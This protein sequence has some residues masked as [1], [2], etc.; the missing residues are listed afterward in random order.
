MSTSWIGA[1]IVVLIAVLCGARGRGAVEGFVSIF[2]E[3][4]GTGADCAWCVRHKV[5]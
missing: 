4:V 2:T 3:R 1:I 5:V